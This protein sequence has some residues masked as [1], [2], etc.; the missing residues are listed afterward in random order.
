V[1]LY[2]SCQMWGGRTA[3]YKCAWTTCGLECNTNQ[4]CISDVMY[5]A[6]RGRLPELEMA[7]DS[8]GTSGSRRIE[9]RRGN[10]QYGDL[11]ICVLLFA[12]CSVTWDCISAS[13]PPAVATDFDVVVAK[14]GIR[15]LARSRTLR[16]VVFRS[17]SIRARR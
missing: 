10:R 17:C 4:T 2:R 16:T 15:S 11:K 5:L 13:D 1:S 3:N 6:K 7:A 8:K 14:S 9:I 12:V